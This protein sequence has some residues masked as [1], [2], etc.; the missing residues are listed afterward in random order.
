ME[1]LE[2]FKKIGFDA[3]L[4]QLAK[5]MKL[6]ENKTEVA[7]LLSY[8]TKPEEVRN[9]LQET[10]EAM[11][12][13]E[14]GVSFIEKDF[15]IIPS[16]LGKL[17]IDGAVLFETELKHISD[18]LS[19]MD[20]ILFAVQKNKDL[21]SLNNNLATYDFPDE[22]YKKLSYYILPDGSINLES[23]KELKAISNKIVKVS[24][25]IRARING[26]LISL[27]EKSKVSLDSQPTIYSG[28]LVLPIQSE[29]K[30]EI[31]GVVHDMSST[32]QTTYVEPRV[33]VELNNELRE[34][35]VEKRRVLYALFK[36]LTE[37]ASNYSDSI[38]ETYNR[39]IA[40]DVLL[41][42]ASLSKRIGGT[43]VD[44]VED[45]L[46]VL[47]GAKNP[48]LILKGE[49]E[50]N[51]IPF[52]L[53]M[54]MSNRLLVISGPN[55]GG[56]SVLLKTIGLYQLMLQVG[57]LLPVQ[58][59]KVYVFEKLFVDIGDD[60]SVEDEL[61]TYTA[62][63]SNMVEVLDC[64]NSKSL[65]LFDEFGAGTD[66]ESGG[67]IAAE[68]LHELL[69]AKAFGVVSTHY[70]E[71]KDI[72]RLDGCLNGAMQ[73]DVKTLTPLY[74]LLIGV[75]G[76]SFAFEVS[77]NVGLSSTL[78]ERARNRFDSQK[79]S[80]DEKLKELNKR[81]VEVT[82]QKNDLNKKEEKL[83]KSLD[84]YKE[85]VEFYEKK[86]ERLLEKATK[87]IN[88]EVLELRQ[89]LKLVKKL[90][91]EK[92]FT[93]AKETLKEVSVKS[94]EIEKKKGIEEPLLEVF[95]GQDVK[96]RGSSNKGE[97]LSVKGDT[98]ELQVGGLRIK[99]K[100]AHLVSVKESSPK[101]YSKGNIER[102]RHDSVVDFKNEL[103]IRGMRVD[104]SMK[105]LESFIDKA[106]LSSSIELRII[107]G[108]GNGILRELVKNV[109]KEYS[110]IASIKHAEV[111][112]G[113]D[114]VTI[115]S[116][117]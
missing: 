16:L 18:L 84:Q 21:S 36:E 49:T 17:N 101:I 109:L 96:V 67:K 108:K 61:S 114:G 7:N 45:P 50:K 24:A 93:K 60:Q 4:E 77:K 76:R 59:G 37:I 39:I 100:K 46:C 20:I 5:E 44:I 104:E 57:L 10:M 111:E 89:G 56:K 13:L 98:I 110:N 38:F 42:K 31:E 3:I 97:V 63:L 95:I 86:K 23:H 113:G 64:V 28:R 8:S 1:E 83:S 112:H 99:T 6:T 14:T 27:K 43:L 15:S 91:K 68:V 71:I 51:I 48:L 26:V 9:K 22:L 78:I 66:P 2:L 81:E 41:S 69:K 65:F 12:L 116:L 33:V 82:K 73:F 70:E 62:H 55:A 102:I 105:E 30:R 72:G 90:K 32:G 117:V 75:P 87:E 85:L 40:F 94:H 29:Y 92:S 88:E 74:T 53:N 80:Y 52:D 47:E 106:I 54:S 58:G 107:H 103:D 79:L 34:L 115:A 25:S 19:S 11:R 35:E